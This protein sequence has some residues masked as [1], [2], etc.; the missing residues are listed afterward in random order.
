MFY[1]EKCL[2]MFYV[3]DAFWTV[4]PRHMGGPFCMLCFCLFISFVK[5]F[6]TGLLSEG[7]FFLHMA[8]LLGVGP[9]HSF[10]L[11]FFCQSILCNMES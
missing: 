8:L 10:E 3:D 6:Y 1:D 11:H 9:V 2:L 7:P 5:Y 4:G